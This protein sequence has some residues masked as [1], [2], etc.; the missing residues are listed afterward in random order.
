MVPTF[1]G[2]ARLLVQD[3]H[4]PR[5]SP[6]GRYI[7]Y[8]TEK[9]GTDTVAVSGRCYVIP[10]V[11]GQPRLVTPEFRGATWPIWIA[12]QTLLFLGIPAG[13]AG[14]HW[15][16]TD[17]ENPRPVDLIVAAGFGPR[18]GLEQRG[19]STGVRLRGRVT[20]SEA[21][22]PCPSTH[23]RRPRPVRRAG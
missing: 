2:D 22:G 7:A 6:D 15:W 21:S 4:D 17:V 13:D 11:G 5:F 20:T 12:D 18:C 1:G 23:G 9:S 3:G 8:T 19:Q 16:A 14:L 10:A